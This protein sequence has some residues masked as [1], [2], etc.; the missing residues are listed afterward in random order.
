MQ[1]ILKIVTC[2]L[3]TYIASYSFTYRDSW[4]ILFV[5]SWQ[6]V[7][8]LTRMNHS[9]SSNLWRGLP[10]SWWRAGG[11]R[12][13]CPPPP[14][15]HSLKIYT[16]QGDPLYMT[17]C[18]WYLVKRDFSNVHYCM[19]SIRTLASHFTRNMKNT[20]MFIWSG[21]RKY[22]IYQQIF[23]S[24]FQQRPAL[25]GMEIWVIRPPKFF[26]LQNKYRI[27]LFPQIQAMS[28]MIWYIKKLYIFY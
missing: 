22:M 2:I 28:V 18:F 16:I 11:G 9:T 25:N 6:K 26:Q 1:L 23:I 24:S 17:V 8:T 20:A 7:S 12:R 15:G 14:P 21:C 10:P 13:S 27:F 4:S 19:Y 3:H 5:R